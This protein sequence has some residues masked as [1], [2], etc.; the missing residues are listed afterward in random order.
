[1]P[2][3]EIPSQEEV[4]DSFARDGF[5]VFRNV[6]SKEKLAGLRQGILDAFDRTAQSGSLFSG[7][8][9]ISGH[10]NCSPGKAAKFAFDTLVDRGIIDIAKGI[11]PRAR[12]AVRV[13]CNLN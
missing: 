2:T 11:L 3:D 12:G 7:G 5:F 13:G 1:M 8:G 10:L 6:V 4:R 9:R